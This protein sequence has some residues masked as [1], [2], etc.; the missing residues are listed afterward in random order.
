MQTQTHRVT[1]VRDQLGAIIHN[2]M[3]LRCLLMPYAFLIIVSVLLRPPGAGRG[4]GGGG[5]ASTY[6]FPFAFP[7]AVASF[8]PP[9]NGKRVD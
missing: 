5:G 9:K 1:F 8:P 4:G 3:T 7:A 2:I 6:L